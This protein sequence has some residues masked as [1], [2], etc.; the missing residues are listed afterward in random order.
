MSAPRTLKNE[1]FQEA[2]WA[3][4]AQVP[5]LVPF[6]LIV[7][8]VQDMPICKH[9]NWLHFLILSFLHSTGILRALVS[10][11]DYRTD[12]MEFFQRYMSE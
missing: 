5:L 7:S 12:Y 8:P 6:V 3:L 4:Y 1:H 9:I 2:T 10:D 11:G